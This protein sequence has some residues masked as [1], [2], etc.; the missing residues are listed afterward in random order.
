MSN[1]ITLAIIV[2]AAIVGIYLLRHIIVLAF[3]LLV[4]AGL[5]LAALWVW[6]HRDEVLDAAQPYLGGIG[7]RLGELDLPDLPDLF[8]D[9]DPSASEDTA[10]PETAG[11][12][13][14][15]EALD[16]REPPEHSEEPDSPEDPNAPEQGP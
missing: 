7:D 4:L 15:S 2:V 1:E 9:Q 10:M 6:E 12:P 14:E 3:R 5:V 11:I 16:V 13:E 8:P